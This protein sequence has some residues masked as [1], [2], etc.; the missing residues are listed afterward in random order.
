M[1]RLFQVLLAVFG[2]AVACF[3]GATIYLHARYDVIQIG[4]SD[5]TNI[6]VRYDRWTNTAELVTYK[7][8]KR[9]S[10]EEFLSK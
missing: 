3:I 1:K 2:F 5:Y 9:E 8:I 7:R 4:R 6:L 10:A